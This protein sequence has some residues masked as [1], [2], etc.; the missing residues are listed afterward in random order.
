[1]S[2]R[3]ITIF[4][5]TL[6]D[7]EQAP[8]IALRPDEKVEIGEQLERLGVDVIE[9]GFAA[10]SP[11]DF[12]GV[13]AVA[14]AVEAGHRRLS[15][16]HERRG[17]RRRRRPHSRTHLARERTSSSRPARCT[18]RRSFASGRTRSS[19]RASSVGRASLRERGRGRVLLRGRDALRSRVRRH[20]S[21]VPR[22]RPARRRSTSPTPSAT[23]CPPST[24]RSSCSVRE[25]CPELERRRALGAL[26]RRPRA[27][28]RELARRG[29]RRRAS[30]SS[31]R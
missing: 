1:M 30:S 26:P 17:H 11:G 31:A 2:S 19:P 18:W 13:Q 5:T 6:R 4:D 15:L 16:P 25:L 14:R 23:C 28:R 22:S 21:A 7:G 24:R 8:G 27:R 12:E 29:R 20:R 9:A 10:S 3:R